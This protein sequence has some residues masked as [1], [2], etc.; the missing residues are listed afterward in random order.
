M[1][2]EVIFRNKQVINIKSLSLW[3]LKGII[4]GLCGIE[5]EDLV[6]REF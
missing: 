2:S 6:V 3:W 1:N 5:T 4:V